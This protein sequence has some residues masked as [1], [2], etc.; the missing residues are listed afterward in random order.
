MAHAA[1]GKAALEAFD[2]PKALSHFT[3]A[4]IEFPTSPDNYMLRSTAFAR[5]TPPRYD[6]A[7]QD[8]EFAVAFAKKREK[9]EKILAAQ[10]RRAVALFGLGKYADAKFILT[11]IQ[12]LRPADSKPLKMEGDMWLAKVERKLKDMSVEDRKHTTKEFPDI[13]IPSDAELQATLQSQLNRD[14]SFRFPEEGPSSTPLPAEVSKSSDTP[15][16][17]SSSQVST[18][19]TPSSVPPSK[20]RHEWYQNPQSVTL[21]IYAKGVSKDAAQIDITNTSVSVSFPH[22]S[23]PT[24]TFDFSLDPLYA[25]IDASQSKGTVMSTKIELIL[26]KAV[27]GQKWPSL[28]GNEP[29]TSTN[30]TNASGVTDP[31]ALKPSTIASSSTGPSYPT[32][33]RNGPKDWDKLASDLHAKAK[34]KRP[35]ETTKKATDSNEPT[36]EPEADDE[37]ESDFEGGDDVDAFFKKLYAGSDEDTRRAMMKSFYESNGTAL[38]TNWSDVGKRKVEEVK[39]KDE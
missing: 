6:L 10:Q 14:K 3:L 36:S 20:F 16:A 19:A 11:S 28:E 37:I 9:R 22:P 21:T 24:S 17:T 13:R 27:A 23:N 39:S 5:L 4:L 29:L 18:P 8:A 38:S 1:R 15:N 30:G 2:Y 26:R 33:S 25:L 32:S 7:L 12:A 34:S 35:K 31:A